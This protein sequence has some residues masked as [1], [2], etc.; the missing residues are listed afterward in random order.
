MTVDVCSALVEKVTRCRAEEAL[1]EIRRHYPEATMTAKLCSDRGIIT[2][3]QDRYILSREY[4]E[5]EQSLCS[6]QCMSEYGRILLGKAR[7]VLIVPK[8]RAVKARMRLLEF[9]NVW[10]FYY[11]VFFYD[12]QGK[13]RRMDRRAWC[14]MMGR[15]YEAPPRAPEIA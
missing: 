7:L 14:E 15:P 12:E 2:V 9:N 13:I 11:Q 4:V 3:F 8:D 1:K 6:P 10:L 5:T